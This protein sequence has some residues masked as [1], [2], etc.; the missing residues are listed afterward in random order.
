MRKKKKIGG[1]KMESVKGKIFAG[2]GIVLII[3]VFFVV[4]WLLFYQES[5]YYTRVDNEKV[6][7]LDSGNMRYEYT[8]ESYSKTGK[9]KE[10]TFKTSRELKNGAYLKLD[11]MLTRGVRS[12][13]EVE[14]NELPNK[15]QEHYDA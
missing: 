12:W 11:V 2:I 5:T 7:M 13:E 8:L 4:F 9:S 10:V 14:F 3:A 15:V 1:K 6:H